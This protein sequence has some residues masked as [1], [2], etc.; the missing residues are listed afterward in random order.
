MTTELENAIN[1]ELKRARREG[2]NEAIEIVS[3]RADKI[4]EFLWNRSYANML[5]LNMN[6]QKFLRYSELELRLN[7]KLHALEETQIKIL[8]AIKN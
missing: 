4:S 6:V 1:N 5:K 2:L 7:S 3:K 8:E